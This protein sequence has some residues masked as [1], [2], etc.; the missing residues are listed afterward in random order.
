MRFRP[1][2]GKLDSIT[3]SHFIFSK[4]SNGFRPLTGKLDSISLFYEAIRIL[5]EM[6]FPS[7]NGEAR[8]N[9]LNVN[10]FVEVSVV[11]DSFRPL[12]GKLDSIKLF[13]EN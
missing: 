11:V 5:R 1:L 13:S 6:R 2:T 9:L 10:P 7:P 3:I 12:T 4:L 8:F